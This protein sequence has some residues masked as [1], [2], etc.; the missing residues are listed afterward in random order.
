MAAPR[1][2]KLSELS[3]HDKDRFYSFL[4]Q[5][6]I[7][8]IS[9]AG[10]SQ[11][12]AV[13]KVVPPS[14]ASGMSRLRGRAT[15]AP[16]KDPMERQRAAST[17]A[18]SAARSDARPRT[19][20]T[21]GTKSRTESEASAGQSSDP[22][23]PTVTL[24]SAQLV[25][26]RRYT[27]FCNMLPPMLTPPKPL[28]VTTLVRF[29]EDIYDQRFEVDA[30]NK[31]EA[32]SEKPMKMQPFP[33]FVYEFAI[34]RYGLKALVSTNCW[35]L[36]SSVEL[37][38]MP[39]ACGC[40][41]GLDSF[42]RF[43]EQ[44]WDAT[45]LHFFLF[46]RS[47]IQT[48]LDVVPAISKKKGEDAPANLEAMAREDSD[49][50]GSQ[51]DSGKSKQPVQKGFQERNLSLKQTHEVLKRMA[52]QSKKVPS[53]RKL[54]Q[55]VVKM[56]DN[57]LPTQE[58]SKRLNVEAD[59]L[60]SIATKVFHDSRAV[61]EVEEEY[62]PIVAGSGAASLKEMKDIPSEVRKESRDVTKRLE[63]A[64]NEKGFKSKKGELSNWALQ[65]AM[66]RKFV[67]E[68]P[69]DEENQATSM[70]L[71]ELQEATFQLTGALGNS[72]PAPFF[73]PADA[74]LRA[75][76]EEFE[77][78]LENNVRELLL[79]AVSDMVDGAMEVLVAPPSRENAI[80]IRNK[81]M[82]EFAKTADILMEC[83]VTNDLE[84]WLGTLKITG[85]ASTKQRS[86][87]Q[88]LH[89]DFQRVL[90]TELSADGVYQICRNMVRTQELEVAAR[91]R[92]KELAQIS[93]TGGKGSVLVSAL[94][95]GY[96]DASLQEDFDDDLEARVR[97][98]LL[99]AVTELVNRSID[100]L[101]DLPNMTG[102]SA[103]VM[104]S[105]VVA[106]F[107]Q[108]ADILMECIV[109]KDYKR[110]LAT[111]KID[112]EGSPKQRRQFEYIREEFL[113]VLSDS[114]TA[115]RVQ[116]ICRSVVG[117][118]ELEVAV[119]TRAKELTLMA[120]GTDEPLAIDGAF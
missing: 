36:V 99:S 26:R 112:G 68:F 55:D 74:L 47:I 96:I 71:D 1:R 44:S 39:G 69:A 78:D 97:Q 60:L 4:V 48:V 91:E 20:T 86:N 95:E 9:D 114:I 33:E 83:V 94:S 115:A 27:R 15:A 34:K 101:S 76:L 100:G 111:L 10:G 17:S 92:A 45:D 56:M 64:F 117:I 49:D 104:K 105:I 89:N 11:F 110:W 32:T 103:T 62:V 31:L 109:S 102:R 77:N 116:Q 84:K 41:A 54:R 8:F 80:G 18:A 70:G 82:N 50:E 22:K 72:V 57:F 118:N 43:L 81:L 67:G 106:E 3:T 90:G 37:L 42:G 13:I 46:V 66:R 51:S 52:E 61:A 85:A 35:S 120:S 38:R 7:E 63:A 58:P 113:E 87:F 5:N 2:V 24:K 65:V 30:K 21:N 40:S 14:T 107:S 28:R 59:R 16:T 93:S 12:K 88:S 73:Q 6:K 53:A 119:Q 79:N 108:T 25:L 98:L 75:T 29:S 23:D 19:P